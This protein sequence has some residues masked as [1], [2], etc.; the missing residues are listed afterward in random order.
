MQIEEKFKMTPGKTEGRND[1]MKPPKYLAAKQSYEKLIQQAKT[2][3]IRTFLDREK[4]RQ[5]Q[6]VKQQLETP[7]NRKMIMQEDLK[8]FRLTKKKIS[9]CYIIN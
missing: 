7:I 8:D 6:Y 2:K 3:L 5:D 1:D 9:N 4:R